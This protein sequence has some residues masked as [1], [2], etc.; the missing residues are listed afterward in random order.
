MWVVTRPG[1]PTALAVRVSASREVGALTV[2]GLL[3]VVL[4]HGHARRVLP[5]ALL[6]RHPLAGVVRR[7][8]WSGGI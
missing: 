5:L 2:E 8:Q 6:P 4:A 3:L 7:G 1:G